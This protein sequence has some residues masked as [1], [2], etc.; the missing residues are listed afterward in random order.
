MLTLPPEITDLI[1]DNLHGYP[2]TLRACSRVSRDWLA[3][4]R[5]HLFDVVY[6]MSGSLNTFIDLQKSPYN[7]FSPRIR[8]LHATG[9]QHDELTRLWPLLPAFRHLR[10]LHIYGIPLV[11]D[12]DTIE[13]VSLTRITT[14]SLSRIRF[15]SYTDLKGLLLQFPSVNILKLER[16]TCDSPAE[17]IQSAPLIQLSL[18]KLHITLT[19]GLL[20]WLNGTAFCLRADSVDMALDS[21]E[22]ALFN[23]LTTLGTQLKRLTLRFNSTARLTVFGTQLHSPLRHNTSLRCLRIT[24]AFWIVGE[25]RI[26]VTPALELL[27]RQ[28]QSSGLEELTFNMSLADPGTHSPPDTVAEIL[29]GVGFS[30]LRRL[31][32]YGPWDHA[33][34]ILRKQIGSAILALFPVQ[35]S[36]GTLHIGTH[37]VF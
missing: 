6:L 20:G 12:K 30:S 9:F 8:N 36:R 14:L 37:N 11:F 26:R 15:T 5:H 29:D 24:D 13:L 4:S 35:N 27:L 32:F 21:M 3:A 22:S 18:D 23:Y 34:D 1:I 17:E 25:N 33:N 7:T 28:L 10:A 2:S 16:I 19:S 31:E